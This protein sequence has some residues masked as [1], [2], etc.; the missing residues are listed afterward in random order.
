ML[1]PGAGD[2]SWFHRWRKTCVFLICFLGMCFSAFVV[3]SVKPPRGPDKTS[4]EIFCDMA[5]NVSMAATNWSK[6]PMQ[7]EM[8]QQHHESC[9][10]ISNSGVLLRYKHGEEIDAMTKVIRFNDAPVKGFE[11]VVGAKDDLRLM[12]DQFGQAELK[13]DMKVHLH[14]TTTYISFPYRAEER[15]AMERLQDKYPSVPIFWGDEG[16]QHNLSTFM[17][18]IYPDEWFPQVW[19]QS[20]GSPARHWY[21]TTGAVGM[22]YA[23]SLCDQISAYGMATTAVESD[24]PYHYYDSTLVP[25]SYLRSGDNLWHR[26]FDAEKD[27]WKRLS[28]NGVE[29]I[30]K[31]NKVWIP[32][33]SQVD[34]SNITDD[35]WQGVPEQLPYIW[36]AVSL[37]GLLPVV[38]AGV[39]AIKLWSFLEAPSFDYAASPVHAGPLLALRPPRGGGLKYKAANLALVLYVAL[40]CSMDITANATAQKHHARYP[41]NPVAVVLLTELS[42]M[43][44]STFLFCCEKRKAVDVKFATLPGRDL[45]W[46]GFCRLLGKAAI[47]LSMVALLY[48]LNNVLNLK[49]LSKANLDS[50]VVWRN[51]TIVFN[52]FLWVYCRGRKLHPYQWLAVLGFFF[53]CCVNTVQV[54]GT[55]KPPN[56]VVALMLIAALTSSLASVANESCLKD[57]DLQSLGINRLNQILYLQT[58][59]I[60]FMLLLVTCWLDGTEPLAAMAGLDSVALTLVAMQTCLGLVVSRVLLH[61]DTMAKTM[62]GGVREVLTLFIAPLYVVS[63]ID[64][65]SIC[66]VMWVL[67]S[68]ILYFHAPHN[69]GRN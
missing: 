44:V 49:I 65:V 68:I 33:F 7:S 42:K 21:A 15:H 43:L 62:A 20:W 53:G 6:S 14:N 5:V 17:R 1:D 66:S 61:A 63:R 38:L 4:K 8:M 57:L 59:T 52:A 25:Q 64:W 34:C 56:G 46:R 48:A 69:N 9:A 40:L 41:W 29:A 19:T 22:F 16:L 55:F 39:I 36:F 45:G 24:Y 35:P 2:I 12:N 50:Y 30:E 13:G 58:A 26:T 60:L 10:V 47:R 28:L 27:L 23:M 67:F 31:T 3:H 54:D 51:T 11:A 18:E 37:A 32:G